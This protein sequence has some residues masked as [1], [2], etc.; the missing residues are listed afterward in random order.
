[1]KEAEFIALHVLGPHRE[2]VG[3]WK[4]E[5]GNLGVSPWEHPNLRSLLGLWN[6]RRSHFSM[7]RGG[8]PL[9]G[10]HAKPWVEIDSLQADLLLRIWLVSLH[11]LEKSWKCVGPSRKFIIG[12]F[13]PFSVH[14]RVH[15]QPCLTLAPLSMGFPRQEYTG[16]G[17]HFLLQRIFPTQEVNPHPLY[18]Q[19]LLYHHT[20]CHLG[21]PVNSLFFKYFVWTYWVFKIIYLFTFS[22]AG[23]S[24]LWGLSSSCASWASHDSGFSCFR[25][26]ALGS[27]GFSGCGM[28]AL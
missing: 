23:S 13:L 17:G 11:C 12:L 3:P 24:L 7:D 2:G 1:M 4:Q 6:G 9:S 20:S 21:R 18:C 22:C 25:A 14:S 27:S 26:W 28:W 8:F 15:G 10:D 16:V 19:S 5:C